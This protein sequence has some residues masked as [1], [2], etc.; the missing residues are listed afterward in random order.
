[1]RPLHFHQGKNFI[2]FASMPSGL[3][4]LA[5][6]PRDFDAD[7]MAE[8]L[9]LLPHDDSR[10]Y[11]ANIDRV[12]PAHFAA[13]TD[14]AIVQRRYWSPPSGQVRSRP[15]GEYEEELRG[16]LDQAVRAQLRGAGDAIGTHLSSGLDSSIVTTSAALQM[17]PRK[18]IAFTA[19]PRPGFNGPTPSGV[20]A[21]EGPLAK[22]TSDLYA[23]I[24]HVL[25]ETSG[26][27]A[28]SALD[29]EHSYQQQP[30]ANLE[31]A[32]WGR[33]IYRLAAQ[34]GLKTLLIGSAG[35]LSISY[36][37]LESLAWLV[38]R[39]RLV[40][41]LATSMALGRRGMPWHSVGAQLIGPFLPRRLWEFALKL[42]G[43]VTQLDDYSLVD[44]E[45]VPSLE[46][47]AKALG[48]DLSYRP[49]SDP[50]RHRFEALV[51]TDG[52]NYFKGILG[53]WGI[54]V[55]DP[56]ADKRLIEYC[57]TIPP[58]EFV[59]GGRGRSLARR[60]FGNRLPGSVKDSTLRG[61]QSADWCETL[62]SDLDELRREAAAIDRCRPAG[63]VLDVSRLEQLIASWPKER[64]DRDDVIM[65]YRHGV[66]R[67][68]A[69]GHFM[70]K[71]SGTN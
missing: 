25:V 36:S 4:A 67:G 41:A 11:F 69:A 3:H 50:L 22:V 38:K 13:V 12:K 18:V 6:V 24:E 21:D 54:N 55:L 39:G 17:A 10:T 47:R 44:P 52:G 63:R 34:R 48:F 59:R 64:W 71:V 61:Y 30:I 68:I 57:L 35:N 46:R 16:L 28:L 9:A 49:S 37:G 62:E 42:H 70:R 56:T 51:R 26:K 7:F 45:L 65:R 8:S 43:R 29:R 58:T 66:L 19:V 60:A 53:E 14:Q 1:M 2:A 15:A 40:P 27:S 5:E 20:V 33:E 32:I 23:N 31:N